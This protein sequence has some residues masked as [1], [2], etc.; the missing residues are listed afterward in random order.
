LLDGAGFAIDWY[1]ESAG[2]AERWPPFSA[3]VEAMPAL[4]QEMGESAATAL[5]R[6]AEFTLQIQPT[7]V[8]WWCGSRCQSLTPMPRAAQHH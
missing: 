2:W 4:T 5:R 8:A 1:R 3:V 6:E 7:A